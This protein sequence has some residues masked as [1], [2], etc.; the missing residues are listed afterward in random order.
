V[1]SFTIYQRFFTEDAAGYGSAMSVAV[2]FLIFLMLAAAAAARRRVAAGMRKLRREALLQ[3]G[4]VAC[5]LLVVLPFLWVVAAGF[6]TQ[7]N[8]LMGEVWF[9][10]TLAAYREVLFSRTSDFLLNAQ[11]L[12]GRRPC[13]H[14]HR[15]ARRDARRLV[16]APDGVAGAGGCT[17]CWSGRWPS[18]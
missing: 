6:R 9:E 17:C 4:L 12:R 13:Q 11:Q 3:L 10:P 16:A 5:G 1:V 15:A 14:R 8:L 2:I 7:I 18:R